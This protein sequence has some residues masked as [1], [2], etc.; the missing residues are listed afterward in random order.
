MAG[1]ASVLTRVLSAGFERA[2]P[3]DPDA[4]KGKIEETVSE[5]LGHEENA[6]GQWINYLTVVATVGPDDRD[7]RYG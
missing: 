2:Q 1:S 6:I 5:S 4:N 7:T 3:Q